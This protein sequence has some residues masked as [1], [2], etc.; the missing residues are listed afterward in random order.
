MPRFFD[1]PR[2]PPV[3]FIAFD[4]DLYSSTASALRVLSMPG[5]RSLDH[6]ALYFDD[7]EHSISRHLAGE[8]LAI[9]EFN[10]SHSHVTIDR[11]RGITNDRPVPGGLVPPKNVH[12]AQSRRDFIAGSRSRAVTSLT[13]NATLITR[14]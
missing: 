7:T 3:G 5:G 10:Q 13:R 2:V 12:G 6:V 1:D 4:L 14:S 8:L 9:D 11:W